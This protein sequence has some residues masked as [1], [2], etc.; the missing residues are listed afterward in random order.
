MD[1]YITGAAILSLR[2]AKG[3]TQ[4]ELAEKIDVSAKT[5]SKWETAKGLPGITLLDPLA[6]ALGVS[7]MELMLGQ[8]VVN[9]NVSCNML[10]T[11][12]YVC[13]IC[14]NILHATDSALISCCGIVLRVWLLK[15]QMKRTELGSNRSRTNTLLSSTT[16]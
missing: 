15:S 13:P 12:L 4:A 1:T 7:V 11:A 3:M 2:E 10:R 6:R 16:I 14:G 9:R 8:P 5:V